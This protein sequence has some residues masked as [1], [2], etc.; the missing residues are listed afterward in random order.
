MIPPAI[1]ADFRNRILLLIVGPQIYLNTWWTL[2]PYTGHEDSS[3]S[4]L[5]NMSSRY[6]ALAWL[7]KV[8]TRD[9]SVQLGMLL[10]IVCSIMRRR[11]S[12]SDMWPWYQLWIRLWQVAHPASVPDR[13]SPVSQTSCLINP[14]I[15]EPQ[16]LSVIVSWQWAILPQPLIE[17]RPI[18]TQL[19]W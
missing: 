16:P 9:R 15:P 6:D 12:K 17:P 4:I 14:R 11:L 2:V 8:C 10:P 7:Y 3:H 5:C 19:L 1:I 18:R 13:A